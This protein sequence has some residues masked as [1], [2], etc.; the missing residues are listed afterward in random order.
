[1]NIME[2]IIT[3]SILLALVLTIRQVFVDKIMG[4]FRL[5]L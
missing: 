1:M 3:S 2:W 4:E 5:S